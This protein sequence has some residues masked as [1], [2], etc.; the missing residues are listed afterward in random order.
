MQGEETSKTKSRVALVV[1]AAVMGLGIMTMTAFGGRSVTDD[2]A[3]AVDRGPAVETIA[4]AAA[5]GHYII[6]APGRLRSRQALSV[7]GEVAGK[8]T[9]VNPQFVLGGR[10]DQGDILFKVN[11]SDFE[12]DV[13]SARA[14]ITSA[15]ASVLRARL[16]NDRRQKLAQSSAVSEA[17]RDQAVADLAS[18][19]ANLLQAKAQLK[20]AEENLSRVT[21]RAPF[22]ALVVSEDVS[23]DTYVSPGQ[24]LGLII[25]TRLGELVAGLAPN[26]AA[27]V[28][29]TLKRNNGQMIATAVPNA[30]SVGSGRLTGTIDLFSPSIDETSRSALVVGVFPD[31]F[32]AENAGQIFA[33]DFM[34]LQI[35]V[36]S[37]QQVWRLPAGSVRKN[38]YVWAV[39]NGVLARRDVDVINTDND[40]IFVTSP[41]ALGD[42]HIMLTLLS[43]EVEGMRVQAVQRTAVADVRSTVR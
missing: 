36:L 30:G 23:Q 24:T 29:Q 40:S 19:E 9:Y 25:D 32:A 13:A 10:L 15:E 17:S 3:N 37:D 7:V 12:A 33:N 20:R 5:D 43:E 26:E 41:N 4:A 38:A 11:A 6:E 31:A 14:Q 21:V 39:E 1:G 34:T 2:N 16:D 28:A 42:D 22:P 27:A 8:I 35:Q 18:A